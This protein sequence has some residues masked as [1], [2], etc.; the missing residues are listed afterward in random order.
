MT[1]LKDIAKENEVNLENCVVFVRGEDD[2]LA[3]DISNAGIRQRSDDTMGFTFSITPKQALK[4]EEYFNRFSTG[5]KFYFDIS[6]TGYRPVYYRGLSSMTKE[7]SEEYEPKFNITL[8][9][10]KAIVEPE[11]SYFAPACACCEF[12][13]I[14]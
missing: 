13:H 14:D 12:C 1:E 10:Q 2:I 11:D 7:V 3:V 9:A 8:F 4:L 6:Q 5:E